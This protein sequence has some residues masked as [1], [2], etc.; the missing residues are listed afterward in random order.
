MSRRR[1]SSAG[2]CSTTRAS[3]A[4]RRSAAPA[5]TARS[6]AFTDA[7]AA[8]ASAR[9]GEVHPAAARWRSPTWRTRPSLTWANPTQRGDSSRRRWCRCSAKTRSNS[10]WRG[11][12]E[13]LLARL[14]RRPTLSDA[15]PRRVPGRPR[16]HHARQRDARPRGL[17]AD[18][19]LGQLAVR[20]RAARAT[21]GDLAGGERGARRSSRE[22]TECFH[23][24][25]GFNFTGT[26]T[27]V[28]KGFAEVE[29]HNT[30]LYNIDGKG[31]YPSAERRIA[32]A[33]HRAR[34]HGQVQGTVAAQHRRDRALH[35]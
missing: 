23:C 6:I 34:G 20:S 12:D 33:H 11:R 19:G 26:T 1:S 25:G 13:Q 35:A 3:R 21:H 7:Q 10:A 5:A 31:A 30:G 24:H 18:L 16:R 15:V 22:Q 29:F 17:P 27:Y 28:G 4:T 2:T 32:G 9:P 8:T 14:A